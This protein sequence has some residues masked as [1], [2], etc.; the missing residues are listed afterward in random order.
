MV[1]AAWLALLVGNA[2][3]L[4]AVDGAR[5]EPVD[6]ATVS[7][8]VPGPEPTPDASA[9][10]GN[11]TPPSDTA[12]RATTTTTVPVRAATA[13]QGWDFGVRLTPTCGPVGGRFTITLTLGTGGTSVLSVV[14]ADS[15][16]YGTRDFGDA[17]PDGTHTFSWVAAAAPG[18]GLVIIAASDGGHKNS[19]TKSVPFRVVAV[20]EKC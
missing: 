12:G 3:G 8:V 14:Y 5:S 7:S 19:G 2:V 1:V 4:V 10:S 20:G 9:S 11:P 15:E 6:Q 13:G 16:S 17:G 18:N